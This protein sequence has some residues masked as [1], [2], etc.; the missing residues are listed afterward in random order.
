MSTKY[1]ISKAEYTALRALV[2]DA[3]KSFNPRIYINLEA[4]FGEDLPKQGV[5]F[6]KPAR[7]S[8]STLKIDT[9]GFGDVHN[10]R[11][12]TTFS[13]MRRNNWNKPYP[14]PADIASIIEALGSHTQVRPK[15]LKVILGVNS[16]PFMW[17]EMKYGIT[18]ATLSV[19][20]EYLYRIDSIEMHT[21]SDLIAHDE[22]L[23][24]LSW[25]GHRTTICIHVPRGG[26]EAVRYIEPG[27]PSVERRFDAARKLRKAGF[28]V[29]IVREGTTLGNRDLCVPSKGRR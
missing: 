2:A 1:Q 20:R 18:K 6:D 12:P 22:Y 25:L 21:R 17:M 23:E 29:R 11:T 19:L 13:K 26:S 28:K 24:E 8:G 4:R 16:D 15:H 27:A 3:P 5:I 9:Y 7:R 10:V 14:F